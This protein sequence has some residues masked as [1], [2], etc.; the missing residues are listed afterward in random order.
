MIKNMK[1]KYQ[2][3]GRWFSTQKDAQNAAK[4]IL[5]AGKAGSRL[6][7]SEQAFM[8][9]YFE[10]FHN[11]WPI[12]VGAGINFIAR[13]TEPNYGKWLAFHIFRVDGTNTDISY[14]IKNKNPKSDF[15]R[16]LRQS[17][18]YQTI[19]YKRRVFAANGELVCEI[20]GEVLD[21]ESAHVDH[22]CPTFDEIAEA[23]ISKMGIEAFEGLVVDG[24]D[25]HTIYELKD[26]KIELEFSRFHRQ[27]AKYRILSQIA[28]LSHAK[29]EHRERKQAKSK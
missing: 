10:N 6:N 22:V 7:E 5:Y 9:S 15:K 12:K 26:K 14:V 21:F 18:K 2:I 28:N 4:E 13:V 16:A 25:N 3:G 8:I 27:L 24:L 19:E 17:I 11:S 23:F 29:H 1:Q 20:T